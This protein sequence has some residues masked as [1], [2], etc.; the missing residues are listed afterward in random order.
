MTANAR[1]NRRAK[2][3]NFIVAW[4]QKSAKD[5]LPP[6]IGILSFLTI[7]QLL[8]WSGLTRLPGPLSVWTDT[9]TRELL[10]YPY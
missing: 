9:R 1:A 6:I 7:W 4:W 2:S 5:I 10:L 8:S 3:G